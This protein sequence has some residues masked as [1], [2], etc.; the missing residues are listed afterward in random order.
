MDRS[1]DAIGAIVNNMTFLR[2]IIPGFISVESPS[3]GR[4]GQQLEGA[5]EAF[6][7]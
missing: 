4:G 7:S 6:S 3:C 5:A 1:R 2:R